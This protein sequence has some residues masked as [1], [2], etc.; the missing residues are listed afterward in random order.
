MSYTKQKFRDGTVLTAAQL[1]KIEDGLCGYGNGVAAKNISNTNLLDQLKKCESGKFR[2]ENV[3]NAPNK[4]WWYYDIICDCDT[5]AVVNAYRYGTHNTY[6][7]AAYVDGVLKPWEWVNP[8]MYAGTEYRTTKRAGG[9]AVYTKRIR[10]KNTNAVGDTKKN[11]DISIPHGIS[12]FGT[13]QSVKARTPFYTLP[14]THSNGAFTGVTGV[15][16]N[17]INLRFYKCTWTAGTTWT[18]D[19]EYTKE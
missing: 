18:I 3:T 4:Y 5:Y 17:N 1:N 13:I 19:L 7:R 6:C 16:E 11:T 12:N 2:G 15:G 14:F 8:P 9:Y 10:W